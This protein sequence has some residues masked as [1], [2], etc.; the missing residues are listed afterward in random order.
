V[1][2]QPGLRDRKKA[3]TRAAL[4][5]AAAALAREHGLH[6]VTADAIA[7]RANVSTRTFHNYFAS[8]EEAVLV[9][10]EGLIELWIEMLRKRPADE[11]IMDSLQE[12]A[13]GLVTDPH[14][15]FDEIG[16]CISVVEESSVLL[17]RSIEAERRYSRLLIDVIAERT[18]TDS[19]TDLLP[20]LIHHTTMGAVKAAIDMHLA[21]AEQSPGSIIRDAFAQLRRGFP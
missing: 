17:A 1:S 4:A 7:A 14:W 18:G 10:L 3:A 13:V 11:H 8:K 9:Y 21:G 19:S 6:V 15:S 2:L 5:E 20:N 16:A 12:C